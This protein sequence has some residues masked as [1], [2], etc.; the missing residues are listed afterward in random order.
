MKTVKISY[1]INYAVFKDGVPVGSF[2]LQT[3][4]PNYEEDKDKFFSDH[5]PH[6]NESETIKFE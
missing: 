2:K 4:K 3:D 6:W 5:N 1:D